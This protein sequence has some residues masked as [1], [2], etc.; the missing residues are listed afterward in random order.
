MA[1]GQEELKTLTITLTLTMAGARNFR[2]YSVW[3]EAVSF[4]TCVYEVTGK[5]PWFEKKGL[6]DQLQRAAVSISSNIAEGAART[7]DADFA[8]FL[9]FALGSAF[10]VETQ[11]TIAKNVGYIPSGN[12]ND[13][14]NEKDKVVVTY[15]ELMSKLQR[16]ER[17]LNGLINSIRKSQG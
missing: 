5:L 7:S 4:A 6:C 14:L 9:D 16:I 13:N 8:H 2:E 11:L 15:E 17:Q 12:D 1:G 10:E 3:K